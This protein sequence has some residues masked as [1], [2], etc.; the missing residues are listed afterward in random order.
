MNETRRVLV[1]GA[2][3]TARRIANEMRANPRMKLSPVG[4]VHEVSRDFE[5]IIDDLPVVGS[6]QNLS[7]VSKALE[8][9]QVLIALPAASGKRI[10]QILGICKQAKLSALIVPT[11]CGIKC[12][13]DQP[14]VGCLRRIQIQ[15]LLR[16]EPFLASSEGLREMISQRRV[17]VTGAGGSIGSELCRQ[18]ARYDPLELVLLGHGEHSIFTLATHLAR[19][20]PS[21]QI[22]RV[23]AD[24]RDQDRLQN[25][26][27]GFRPQ[28]V[29]HAAAHK[30]V[31]LMEENP[32]DAITNNVL[33]TS[34][35]VK[36]AQESAVESFVLVSTDKAVNPMSVMGATKRIAELIVC[37]AAQQSKGR[38]VSVRFGNVLGSRGSVL[39]VFREQIAL[40]GPVTVTHPEM[41]RYFMTIQEAVHL[42][43]QAMLLGRGGEIFVLDMGKPVKI[44]DIVRDMIELEAME[45][46]RDIDI[47]FTGV[48]PGEK[49]CEELSLQSDYYERTQHKKIFVLR[50]GFRSPWMSKVQR[51]PQFITSLDDHIGT[52][53]AAARVG[54]RDLI[55]QYLAQ[56]IPEYKVDSASADL[57]LAHLPSLP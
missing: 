13:H 48:R 10:R 51:G 2:N 40:G 9:E 18:I 11:D 39:S 56:I 33:G 50:N 17:L 26:F 46:G 28:I 8:I 27:A 12:H 55:R 30:H 5:G 14:G 54:E 16:N 47:E 7:E 31:A 1:I 36:A 20:H 25:T 19:S 45:G 24:V 41:R 29:F 38:Y 34:N 57:C 42:V 4:F 44:A 52:L 32:E 35:I 6:L 15:D 53:I 23:I 49:L 22:E 37:Q 21:L 3:Q 43:L